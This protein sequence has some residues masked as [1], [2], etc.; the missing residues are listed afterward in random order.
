MT[1]LRAGGDST[2]ADTVTVRQAKMDR[3]VPI[4]VWIIPFADPLPPGEYRVKVRG[5]RGLNGRVSPCERE[6]RIRPPAPPR[7][8]TA[9]AR[10]RPKP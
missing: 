9:A 1:I 3:P 10:P 5:V 2:G 8:T 7:D 4:Q 6:L